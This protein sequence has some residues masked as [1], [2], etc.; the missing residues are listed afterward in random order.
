MET[1]CLMRILRIQSKTSPLDYTKW[2]G[3]SL[4]KLS[5][6]KGV[7]KLVRHSD[8][9]VFHS[10]STCEDRVFSIYHIFFQKCV[11]DIRGYSTYNWNNLSFFSKIIAE[12]LDFA[13]KDFEPSQRCCKTHIKQ[14]F[15]LHN[16]KN[17]VT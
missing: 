6:A 1:G 15:L 12:K 9:F 8:R 13:S 14:H 10:F 11:H 5:F 3:I 2:I 17:F 4:T 16:Y 7:S